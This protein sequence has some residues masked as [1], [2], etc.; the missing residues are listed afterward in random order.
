MT[1]AKTKH[2]PKCDKRRSIRRFS[3]DISRLD[4]R[5][6]WCKLCI[7]RLSKKYLKDKARQ[8]RERRIALRLEALSHY[9]DASAPRCLCCH[10]WRIEFLSIDH[11][12]GGGTKHK[13]E[14]CGSHLYLWLKQQNYPEG[15]R[16]LCHNCNQSLG[17]YGYCPH[18]NLK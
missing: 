9:S 13:R 16:V 12:K 18:A 3:K 6:G 7:K 8:G 14:V 17:A 2:C 10:E 4:G 5:N 11:E 15:F 1:I